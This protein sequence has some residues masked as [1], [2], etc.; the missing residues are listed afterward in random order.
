VNSWV[1]R[2]SYLSRSLNGSVKPVL[3]LRYWL[4]VSRAGAAAFRPVPEDM[5]N[6]LVTDIGADKCRCLVVRDEL[7]LT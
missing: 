5:D 3:L 4:D 2:N 7:L 1:L 6:E